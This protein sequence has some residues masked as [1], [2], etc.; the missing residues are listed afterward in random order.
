[1]CVGV[2]VPAL[3]EFDLTVDGSNLEGKKSP[4]SKK[5]SSSIGS[6]QLDAR[7]SALRQDTVEFFFFLIFLCLFWT[8][9]DECARNVDSIQQHLPVGPQLP[10]L[11]ALDRHV[12]LAGHGPQ[13]ALDVGLEAL[14]DDVEAHG[15]DAEEAKG[16]DLHRD[17][18]QRNVLALVHLVEVVGVRD[19]GAG[20]H[21]GTDELEEEGGNVEGHED[22]GHPA[23]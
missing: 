4:V 5:G 2:A 9:H 14:G 20:D 16:Q 7:E 18:G 10:A 3:G 17:T 6:L 13:S 21:D 11:D 8:Y 1:M 22:G 19:G 15:D 12:L 23:G